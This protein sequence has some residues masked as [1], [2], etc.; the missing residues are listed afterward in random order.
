MRAVQAIS[1]DDL[2][3]LLTWFAVLR[4]CAAVLGVEAL[5]LGVLSFVRPP[6]GLLRVGALVTLAA[7]VGAGL[8]ARG[9]WSTYVELLPANLPRSYTLEFG[10]SYLHS[11]SQAIGYYTTAG[12]IAV[13]ATGMLL[14]AG[15]VLA[16]KAIW[17]RGRANREGAALYA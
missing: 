16:G 7:G 13:V 1:P 11:I 2:G 5:C 6:R 3:V 17:G 10:L 9:A 15:G 8:L 12:W 4:V 14:I